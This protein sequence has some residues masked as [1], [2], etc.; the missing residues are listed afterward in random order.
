MDDSIG[1]T[2]GGIAATTTKTG[3]SSGLDGLREL[4]KIKQEIARKSALKQTSDGDDVAKRSRKRG[5]KNSRND[6]TTKRAVRVPLPGKT[7]LPFKPQDIVYGELIDADNQLEAKLYVE[8]SG[9]LLIYSKQL[10]Q[11]PVDYVHT[12]QAMLMAREDFLTNSIGKWT[13]FINKNKPLL[14]E[15]GSLTYLDKYQI[16]S[17]NERILNVATDMI[18]NHTNQADSDK[19]ADQACVAKAK[20]PTEHPI[21]NVKSRDLSEEMEVVEKI[22]A[23]QK[24]AYRM[25]ENEATP[26]DLM[27]V[28]LIVQVASVDL[29]TRILGLE[30]DLAV[31]LI[32]QLRRMH[33]LGHCRKDET[34]PILINS[35]DQLDDSTFCS[36]ES[37]A[38]NFRSAVHVEFVKGKKL[39]YDLNE[40][41]MVKV[42]DE[43]IEQLAKYCRSSQDRRIVRLFNA[44]EGK[45][46]AS[47][48]LKAVSGDDEPDFSNVAEYD[49]FHSYVTKY[50]LSANWLIDNP[51]DGFPWVQFGVD[52][53]KG[54]AIDTL[55]YMLVNI[56]WIRA[57][58]SEQALASLV[59]QVKELATKVS[60]SAAQAMA[61][62]LIELISSFKP[63]RPKVAA[64]QL[65]IPSDDYTADKAKT[66]SKKTKKSPA[67]KSTK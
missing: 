52:N 23:V 16:I 7:Q 65:A 50:M 57:I 38:D 19:V 55:R 3:V 17:S 34:Y 49:L 37:Q 59:A 66:K 35:I 51:S 21:N 48:V 67:T 2:T 20:Q 15:N 5:R 33:A 4:I 14:V 45:V 43:Y 11:D 56:Y 41:F 26:R 30:Q 39:V 27:E 10:Y 62:E 47:D 12:A 58:Y 32:D 64:N 60:S 42:G 24:V 8:Q 54:L 63:A 28:F 6:D 22:L 40:L 18:I 1:V 9:K 36:P 29:A 13:V 31:V 46:L 44:A 53:T 25:F 61:N